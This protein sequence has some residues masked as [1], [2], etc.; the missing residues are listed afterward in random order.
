MHVKGVAKDGICTLKLLDLPR[1]DPDEH[2]NENVIN[3][4]QDDTNEVL[5][6]LDLLLQVRVIADQVEDAD[7]AMR[8]ERIKYRHNRNYRHQYAHIR[9]RRLCLLRVPHAHEDYYHAQEH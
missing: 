1:V 8:D 7:E 9:V 3:A 5:Q 4:V 2:E 6:V